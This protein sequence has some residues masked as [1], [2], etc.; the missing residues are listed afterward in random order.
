MKAKRHMSV[1]WK[2]SKVEYRKFKGAIA[3]V[4]TVGQ[5]GDLAK[6]KTQDAAA[7]KKKDELKVKMAGEIKVAK[8]Q[9]EK[10]IRKIKDD[11]RTQVAEVTSKEAVERKEMKGVESKGEIHRK[12]KREVMAIN[13]ERNEKIKMAKKSFKQA[14]EVIKAQALVQ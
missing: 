14:K 4:L 5:K 2:K 11:E 8:A 7:S 6:L 12:A 1:S 3:K 13:E 9:K 10:E